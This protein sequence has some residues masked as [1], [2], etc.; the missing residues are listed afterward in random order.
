M[1][2]AFKWILASSGVVGGSMAETVAKGE[3]ERLP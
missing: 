2:Y 3:A 1:I